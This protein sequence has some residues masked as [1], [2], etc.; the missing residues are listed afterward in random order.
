MADGA[1]LSDG[2]LKGNRAAP[3][4]NGRCV[5]DTKGRRT[6]NCR[7]TGHGPGL[8][9]HGRPC[10]CATGTGMPVARR[11]LGRGRERPGC[12]DAQCGHR[13]GLG[14]A[15][16][17]HP[18]PRVAPGPSVLGRKAVEPG[19][20]GEHVRDARTETDIARGGAVGDRPEGQGV[21]TTIRRT[22]PHGAEPAQRRLRP[23]PLQWTP[24]PFVFPS[25]ASPDGNT[26]V[27]FQDRGRGFA[28][29]RGPADALAAEGAIMALVQ[30]RSRARHVADDPGLAGLGRGL[31][32]GG[33]TG[34]VR[35]GGR[36]DRRRCGG[37]ADHA[38]AGHDEDWPAKSTA[39]TGGDRWSAGDMRHLA[40]GNV[41]PSGSGRTPQPRT[42]PERRFSGGSKGGSATLASPAVY[43][44]G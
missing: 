7:P 8:T 5:F 39:S 1:A 2:V 12:F 4:P 3:M 29:S 16:P 24:V 23:Q 21:V 40:A 13:G 19:G 22:A 34:G 9:S 38:V 32:P 18:S 15:H 30:R 20:A 44:G 27:V 26:K 11:L 14:C 35:P 25:E 36:G 41:R 6:R 31:D 37:N 28:A 17:G 42:L 10:S 43:Y 33:G